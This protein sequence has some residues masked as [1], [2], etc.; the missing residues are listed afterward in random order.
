MIIAVKCWN[1][2]ASK[3][4]LS[5]S[6]S[7]EL[8]WVLWIVDSA[9][10]SNK[11]I[12]A[13]YLQDDFTWMIILV[14]YWNWSATAVWYEMKTVKHWN[15]DNNTLLSLYLL[16]PQMAQT[17]Y[18]L[19]TSG[20]LKNLDPLYLLPIF[21]TLNNLNCTLLLWVSNLQIRIREREI[22]QLFI[23]FQI[24]FLRP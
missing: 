24:G 14:K 7:L 22:L 10:M 15:D 9:Q 5:F 12:I 11:T 13:V 4:L 17:K 19:P 1:C 3:M 18:R 21:S 2:S 16:W 6:Y 20:D 8:S 23:W